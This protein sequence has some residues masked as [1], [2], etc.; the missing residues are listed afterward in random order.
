M[1]SPRPLAGRSVAVTRMASGAADLAD[2]LCA[3]GA[4]VVVVPLIEIAPPADNGSRLAQVLESMAIGDVLV[5]TSVHAVEAVSSLGANL[6][7]IDTATVGTTTA[8]AVVSAGFAPPL[9]PDRQTARDLAEA[10]IGS[11]PPGRVVFAAA[12]NARPDL[13]DILT[14]AG[15]QVDRVESYRTGLRRPPPAMVAAASRCDV[16]TFTSGSTVRGWVEAGLGRT[17]AVSIGPSTSQVAA[18]LGVVVDAEAGTHDLDGVCAAV[19]ALL[20]RDPKAPS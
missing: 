18:R 3:L 20:A 4:N 13:E 10:M 14:S 8:Q 16:V 1:S 15:W 12:D 7:G 17:L 9:V 11:R 2:R 6:T 19:V 5:M